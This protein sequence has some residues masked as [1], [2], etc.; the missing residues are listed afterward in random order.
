LAKTTTSQSASSGRRCSGKQCASITC[1]YR[2]SDEQR[3]AITC[4]Y[5]RSSTAIIAA[6]SSKVRR[7][8][9]S[10]SSRKG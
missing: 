6:G 10:R 9:R 3:A 7:H 5:G 1:I 8:A 4:T 2:R